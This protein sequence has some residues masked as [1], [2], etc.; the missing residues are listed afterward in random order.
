MVVAWQVSGGVVNRRRRPSRKPVEENT[1]IECSFA[2]N[3]RNVVIVRAG[4]FTLLC[5]ASFVRVTPW[6]KLTLAGGYR[7]GEEFVGLSKF[8]TKISS[9][10]YDR[11]IRLSSVERTVKCLKCARALISRWKRIEESWRDWKSFFCNEILKDCSKEF[12]HVCVTF[13]LF[14]I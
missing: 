1:W 14:V 4:V 2:R 8:S 11:F 5:L 6:N 9:T 12:C 7:V 10:I 13:L 3:R